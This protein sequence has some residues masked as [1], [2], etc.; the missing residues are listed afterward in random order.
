MTPLVSVIIPSHNKGR[1]IQASIE[2]VL[3]QTV[4][5]IDILVVDDGSEDET[6]K[7]VRA[8]GSRVTYLWQAQAGVSA[9]RN[10]GVR[11]SRGEY[12]AFLD[13]DD[14]WLAHKLERQ[15]N[16]LEDEPQLD[17]VQCSVYLVNNQLEVVEARRCDPSRDTW[18]DFLL[19][20]NLPG[21]GST[22]L[23]RRRRL[24]SLGGFGEDLVI[25][26]DWDLAC[27]FAR[28][29]SLKSL[30]EFLVLY[31]QHAG[32]RSRVV[33]IHEEPGVL[34]LGRLF[35]DPLV[36]PAIRAQEARIWAR[37]YGMLAGG[38]LQNRQWRDGLSW[39]WRALRTS[40]S[41][42]PYMAG[43]PIRHLRRCVAARQSLSFAEELSFGVM[44]T[45]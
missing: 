30:P 25:L 6:R 8:F 14:L 37:F 5:D 34:S 15:L 27:R 19:F 2:S 10:H 7:Q 28:T 18:L 32:N 17:A 41:V 20:R 33:T 4:K 26:E 44:S 31:R 39:A 9:A 35:A 21:V 42:A 23:A 16:V 13:G 11:A 29:N 12:V 38:Y 3:R 43:L 36:D 45:T 24:E 40:P 22:L 1:T